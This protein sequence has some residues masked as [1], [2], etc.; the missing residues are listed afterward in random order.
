MAGM[1]RR[2]RRQGKGRKMK[3]RGGNPT[4][5]RILD[6]ATKQFAE[7]GLSGARVD[8]IAAAADAN[9]RMI[10]HH[11]G[12]KEALYLAVLDNA[13]LGLRQ[14]ELQL[15]YSGLAPL[16]GLLRLFDF[17]HGHFAAHPE[18]IRLMT[19]ENLLQAVYL[20]HSKQVTTRSSPII[21][22]IANLLRRGEASG[23]LR[24][25]IDPLQLYVTMVALSYFHLSNAHTLS[26]IFRS[27]LLSSR[28]R[29]AYSRQAREMIERS[30]RLGAD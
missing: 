23:E 1:M 30:L 12:S 26:W 28:W 29:N 15:D 10:Y 5:S 3:A 22:L 27:N 19:G 20:K 11:F 4:R 14:Q 24:S 17:L 18:L 6:A 2:V 13:Y 8:A 9:V 25:G 16:E 7:Y 21:A